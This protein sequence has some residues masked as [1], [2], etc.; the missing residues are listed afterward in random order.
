MKTLT[1]MIGIS[2]SGKSTYVN[3]NF[4]DH[5]LISSDDITETIGGEF[6]TTWAFFNSKERYRDISVYDA[7][8]KTICEANMKRGRAIVIDDLN[9][10]KEKIKNWVDLADKYNYQKH[11]V[12]IH[13]SLSTCMTRRNDM[14]FG[15]LTGMYNQFTGLISDDEFLKIFDKC[16]KI[17]RG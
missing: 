2:G 10:D 14:P 12:L 4:P 7:V 13:E 3:D 11:A 15:I 16:L 1:L 9:I 6:I 8:S 17:Y 5:Q